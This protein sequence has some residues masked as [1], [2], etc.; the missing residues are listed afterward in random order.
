M[1]NHGVSWE[2]AY[3]GYLREGNPR[4]VELAKKIAEGSA[5]RRFRI[6]VADGRQLLGESE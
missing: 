4:R 2:E 3:E 1:S 5:I 6:A